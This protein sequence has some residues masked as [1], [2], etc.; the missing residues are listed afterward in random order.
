MPGGTPFGI[1]ACIDA[2]LFERTEAILL[3]NIALRRGEDVS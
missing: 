1:E 2:V 3:R